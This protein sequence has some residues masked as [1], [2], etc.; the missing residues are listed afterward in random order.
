MD[1]CEQMEGCAKVGAC[2]ASPLSDRS[3]EGGTGWIRQTESPSRPSANLSDNIHGIRPQRRI[4]GDG[5]S[6]YHEGPLENGE[7]SFI[8]LFRSGLGGSTCTFRHL[9]IALSHS[10]LAEDS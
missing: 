9:I 3:H 4:P 2:S 7:E 1:H 8:G 5:K 6:G 10:T